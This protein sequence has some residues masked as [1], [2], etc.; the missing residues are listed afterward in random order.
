MGIVFSRVQTAQVNQTPPRFHPLCRLSPRHTQWDLR[1]RKPLKGWKQV[2][3]SLCGTCL[4]RL[5]CCVLPAGV[6]Y[7]VAGGWRHFFPVVLRIPPNWASG[8]L[9]LRKCPAP[10]GRKISTRATDL[11]LPPSPKDTHCQETLT[12]ISGQI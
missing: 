8:W 7:S 9:R 11:G 4:A 1:F 6:C 2:L 12:K 3:C 10:A 5:L